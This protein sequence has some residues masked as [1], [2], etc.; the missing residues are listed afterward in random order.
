MSV[1]NDFFTAELAASAALVGLIF[2]GI[3]INLTRIVTIPRLPSRAL[4]ALIVLLAILVVSS[5]LL[6]PGQSLTLVGSEVL[7]VGCVR[8]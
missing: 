4:L 6:V 1:W 8:G 2:V 5:L 7:I 3:S